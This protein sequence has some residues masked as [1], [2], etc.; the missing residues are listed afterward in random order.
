MHRRHA[1]ILVIPL[2]VAS[3][4]R[5]GANETSPPSDAPYDEQYVGFDDFG[6][7][8]SRDGFV[9]GTVQWSVPYEGKYKKPLLGADFYRKVGRNDLAVRYEDRMALRTGL[10]AGGVIVAVVSS[11][12]GIALL[13]SGQENCGTVTQPSPIANANF[14]ACVDRNIHSGPD[15]G[16]MAL[17]IAGPLLGGVTALAGS[18]I[19]PD[20]VSLVERRR[21]ADR[22]NQTL[23]E[24]DSSGS[25]APAIRMGPMIGA[26]G[27]GLSIGL[28]L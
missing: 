10:I 25:S 7:V 27:A 26:S 19:D 20:P 6:G 8:I 1:A 3:P 21:L 16:A 14:A 12:V 15:A 11:I 4:S 23:R 28:R 24:R 17:A 22:Y 5:A 9:A 13:S 2:L 18:A